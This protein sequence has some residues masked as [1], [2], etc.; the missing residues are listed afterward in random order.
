MRKPIGTGEGVAMIKLKWVLRV[1]AL[2]LV[3][4]LGAIAIGMLAWFIV[5]ACT[6]HIFAAEAV[7]VIGFTLTLLL[8]LAAALALPPLEE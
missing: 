6:S 2:C 4:M 5:M 7:G 3:V 8:S 1:L